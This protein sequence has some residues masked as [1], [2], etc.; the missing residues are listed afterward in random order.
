MSVEKFNH[1]M[2]VL[3]GM[4]DLNK[5]PPSRER[6]TWTAIETDIF[7]D[8]VYNQGVNDW[9]GCAAAIGTKTAEQCKY[10]YRNMR[11]KAKKAAEG[12]KVNLKRPR[13]EE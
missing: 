10:K 11:E 13:T 4:L 5:L 12:V 7:V 6:Q 3:E 8:W 1:H 9:Y 2:E